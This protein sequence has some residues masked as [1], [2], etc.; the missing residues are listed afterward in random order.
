MENKITMLIGIFLGVLSISLFEGR[1][2]YPYA[3]I[4][5]AIVFFI[6]NAFSEIKNYLE[7]VF[8]IERKPGSLLFLIQK[9]S[10]RKPK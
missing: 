7:Y 3:L 6:C 10:K 2:V 9:N 5:I 8:S 1:P 4:E